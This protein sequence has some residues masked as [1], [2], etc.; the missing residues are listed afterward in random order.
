MSLPSTILNSFKGI[1]PNQM[2]VVT[3]LIP[4]P[5]ILHVR[6]DDIP[7]NCKR[8]CSSWLV[9]GVRGFMTS[10]IVTFGSLWL[11]PFSRHQYCPSLMLCVALYWQNRAGGHFRK[12]HRMI[13]HGGAPWWSS[14]V[15]WKGVLTSETWKNLYWC[16]NPVFTLFPYWAKIHHVLH[17]GQG[18]GV[19][20]EGGLRFWKK[21]LWADN[22]PFAPTYQ[23]FGALSSKT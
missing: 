23:K 10:D 8:E 13:G 2:V 17:G 4:L 11:R 14:L 16:N 18:E 12:E 1:I 21:S 15:L 6:E 3:S 7:D 20:G 19:H 5:V 22:Y 9:I